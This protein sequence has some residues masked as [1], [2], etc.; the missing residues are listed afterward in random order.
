MKPLGAV[1]NP[2][3]RVVRL[4]PGGQAQALRVKPGSKL[5]DP[6][7]TLDALKAAI[8]TAKAAGAATMEIRLRNPQ[9]GA[10]NALK[11]HMSVHKAAGAFSGLPKK[12]AE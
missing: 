6:T 3:G 9:Y 12:T 5:L 2:D 8:K 7:P 4:T 10:L 11:K 1:V